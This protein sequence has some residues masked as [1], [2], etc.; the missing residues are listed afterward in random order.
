MGNVLIQNA[1]KNDF[2]MTLSFS[3]KNLDTKINVKE[4][5]TGGVIEITQSQLDSIMKSSGQSKL[6]EDL[7]NLRD[8]GDYIDKE[9]WQFFD[10][11][12]TASRI[13]LD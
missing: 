10:W 1:V 3:Y 13:Q 4:R 6:I 2:S 7:E 12:E 9:F 5:Y 11:L 8:L